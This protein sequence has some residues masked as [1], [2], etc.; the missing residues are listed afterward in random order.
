MKLNRMITLCAMAS[1]LALST[2]GLL[3]QDNGNGGGQGGGGGGGGG[4]GFRRFDP[5]EMQQRIMDNVR[6]ELN[7]TNDTDWSAVQPLVQ[8]VLDARRD[9]GFG[10]MGRLFG[11][12]NRGGAG[13]GNRRGGGPFGG[14]PSPEQ[15][16]LQKALDEDAPAAQIKDLLSKY[17]SAQK[18]KQAKLEQAQADLRA[19]LTS[20]QEAQ[21]TL[22]GLLN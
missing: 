21:A 5:A 10:N 14:Q 7:F 12:R 6:D 18:A 1:T 15:D 17:E 2:G 16:A 11:G 19:V 8:K 4:G 3:A 22:L 13:G 9:V 20:K